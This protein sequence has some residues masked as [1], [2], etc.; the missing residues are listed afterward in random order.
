MTQVPHRTISLTA[1]TIVGISAMVGTGVFVAWNPAFELAGS[2]LLIAL[3]IAAVIAGLNATS[4]ARL[5]R[6]YPES[7]GA[8]IYGR[9]CINPVVGQLAGWSFLVGKIASASAAALAIGIYLAPDYARYF[10]VASIAIV[11]LINVLGIR[12]S[13][14]AMA[15]MISIV[16]A[17]LITLSV[18]AG[19]SESRSTISEQ[20]PQGDVLGVLA[21]AGIL[22]VA[23]AG[24]ARIA[25]LGSEVKNA[26]VTIPKAIAFS[27]AVVLLVYAIVAAVLLRVPQS[28]TSE[29]PLAEL[30]RLV[31]YPTWLVSLAAVL[32]AGSALF[33][34]VAGLGRMIFAM[35]LGGHLPRYFA[36]LSGERSVPRRA[37]LA[38]GV[39]LIVITLA[40]SIAVNLAVSAVFVLIYYGV[41]HLS[42]WNRAGSTL[43]RRI[44]PPV[45]LLANA[46]VVVALVGV[47]LTAR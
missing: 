14:I 45:G 21:G 1:A 31:S 22:F 40:G 3:V 17:T 15:I 18:T 11:V 13:I 37:D 23:V 47:A 35:S 30:A 42:S 36:Q 46:L 33:A 9:E 19:V 2:Y 6:M 7:G 10:S 39:V 29:T 5:A 44:I 34:L 8:Y 32:A 28:L 20:L 16:L 38:I 4:N 26:R 27:F 25:V 24:Y 12:Y 43:L 41:V